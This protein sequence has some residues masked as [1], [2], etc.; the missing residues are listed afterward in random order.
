MVSLGQTLKIQERCEKRLYDHTR[1]VVWKKPFQ[2]KKLKNEMV[3]KM[4]K[5]CQDAGAI[6][7]L[8]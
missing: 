4:A 1:V 6:A 7:Y 8:K 5:F 2:K 3:V